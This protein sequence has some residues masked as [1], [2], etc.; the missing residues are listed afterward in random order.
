MRLAD[1]V[2]S[3][4]FRAELDGAGRKVSRQPRVL[5]SSRKYRMSLVGVNATCSSRGD[6]ELGQPVSA[7]P[8]GWTA[9]SHSRKTSA[10]LWSRHRSP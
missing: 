5:V 7:R 2:V 6:R 8:A 1:F 4:W 3:C 10:A 9:V